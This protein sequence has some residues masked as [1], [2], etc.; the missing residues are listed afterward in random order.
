MA[1]FS[2]FDMPSA[3]SSEKA[4]AAELQ[5]LIAVEQQK[6]QFQAQVCHEGAPLQSL[7]ITEMDFYPKE[8]NKNH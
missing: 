2:S 6:A 4:E 5:R 3:G 1:D 7:S 8:K